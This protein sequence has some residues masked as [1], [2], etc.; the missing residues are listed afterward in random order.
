M[1]ASIHTRDRL[2]QQFVSRLLSPPSCRHSSRRP[3][4]HCAHNPPATH[5]FRRWR[6]GEEGPGDGQGVERDPIPESQPDARSDLQRVGLF[7]I[8]EGDS[9]GAGRRY[10]GQRLGTARCGAVRHGA[11]WCGIVIGLVCRNRQP[12][13]PQLTPVA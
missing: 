10:V 7:G 12:F 4:P 8:N 3:T 9:K 6:H 11:V 13:D 1:K 2:V 5:P